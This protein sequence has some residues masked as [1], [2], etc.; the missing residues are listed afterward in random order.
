M[1]EDLNGTP[2]HNPTQ[3]E[4]REFRLRHSARQDKKNKLEGYLREEKTEDIKELIKEDPYEFEKVVEMLSKESVAK[5]NEVH[6]DWSPDVENQKK[7]L[8]KQRKELEKQEKELE[9]KR[10]KEL[11]KEHESLV[12][13]EVGERPEA[14]LEEYI[15]SENKE[16]IDFFMKKEP[17]KF[18]KAVE[19]LEENAKSEL[20]QIYPN[21]E[22]N[23]KNIREN[24]KKEELIREEIEN[25]FKF[26]PRENPD[27]GFEERPKLGPE[28]DE[29]VK[30]ILKRYD[31]DAFEEILE[32]KETKIWADQNTKMFTR[33]SVQQ[34]GEEDKKKGRDIIGVFAQLM[35]K[36]VS[37]DV[38][39]EL[40]D[41][42]NKHGQGYVN[43]EISK[44]ISENYMFYEN[45]GEVEAQFY[46]GGLEKQFNKF[47]QENNLIWEFK[48][49]LR[50]G[51]K[52]I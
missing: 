41:L 23:L 40:E 30:E 45:M 26:V 51:N 9:E 1:A 4:L 2:S 46:M 16:D 34:K 8:E 47:K 50:N 11:Q 17:L 18:L 14:K 35:A 52:Y 5:L 25:I 31:K 21:L 38:K 7:E 19:S 6:F 3:E 36:G 42:Y 28:I 27:P 10:K 24:S 22:D 15:L 44:R 12:E 33:N 43:K 39:K 20:E 13:K 29:M 37:E 49:V 48:K 32:K